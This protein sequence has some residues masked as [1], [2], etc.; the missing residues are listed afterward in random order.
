[1]SAVKK[2]AMI[3]VMQNDLEAAVDFY[4]KL[5]LTL[6]FHLKNRW[7]EFRLHDLQ[8]G[9]CPTDEKIHYNRTGLVFEVAD[10]NTFYETQKEHISFL[11]KPVQAAHGIMVSIQDP[12]GNIL[13]LY[14]PTPEKVKNLAEKLKTE[15]GCCGRNENGGEKADVCCKSEKI[16]DACCS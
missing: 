14:Q 1:M 7:A 5:G 3:I 15:V 2:V 8:I 16:Q 9:L 12:A 13:D 6:V 10:L 11:D 4:K